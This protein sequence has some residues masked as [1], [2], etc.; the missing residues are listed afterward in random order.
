MNLKRQGAV[1]IIFIKIITSLVH[2]IFLW[3]RRKLVFSA[4]FHST[5][6]T[7]FYKIY[8]MF[9]HKNLEHFILLKR[10]VTILRLWWLCIIYLVPFISEQ[11]PRW[12]YAWRWVEGKV[13]VE[14]KKLRGL[15]FLNGVYNLKK[16]RFCNLREKKMAVVSTTKFWIIQLFQRIA[17]EDVTSRR[18][19]IH[20]KVAPIRIL[21]EI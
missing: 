13:H 3:T 9:C 5:G 6:R 19:R 15:I 20:D 14:V 2:S 1:L 11:I 18:I 8:A 21:L 17:L 4:S 12:V 10:C 16:E 7:L